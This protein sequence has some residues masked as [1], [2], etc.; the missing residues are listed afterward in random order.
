VDGDG[1]EPTSLRKIYQVS[2]SR[3]GADRLEQILERMDFLIRAQDHVGVREALRELDIG[4]GDA[5][6]SASMTPDAVPR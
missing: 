2:P 5:A 4:Y 3:V 6:G 1:I